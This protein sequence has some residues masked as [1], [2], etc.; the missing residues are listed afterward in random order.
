M[1]NYKSTEEKFEYSERLNT[2]YED[3]LKRLRTN[4]FREDTLTGTPPDGKEPFI[5]VFLETRGEPFPT[6]I[7]KAIVRSWMESEIP[8]YEGDIL[9]GTQRPERI[10]RE[11]FS[12]GIQEHRHMFDWCDKYKNRREELEPVLDELHSE[13]V[14]LDWDHLGDL[15]H[16]LFP[17]VDGRDV[18]NQVVT[19][20]LWW[21]GGFQGHTVP[22]YKILVT[23]GIGGVHKR[24][25]D[26][27]A[28]E[29]EQKKIEMLTACKIILEGLR[30][31]ILMHADKAEEKA[32]EGGKWA[33]SLL[34][35][36][37]NCRA[38]AFD[39]PENYYQACQL[40]WFYSLWDWVDCLGRF[41]QFL[42]PFFEKSLGEDRQFTEDLTAALMLK[43]L[44]HGIHNMTL[45]GCDPET[46]KDATNELSYLV[47]QIARRNHETHPRITLRIGED[48]DPALLAL[49]VKMWS[50]GMSDPTVSAD[51]TVIP[52]FVENYG[53]DLYDAR[54]YS[55]LG[56][57]ELEIPG[58]SNFGCEDGS[59]NLAKILEMTLNDG[60]TRF[61]D[62]YRVGLPTGH[63]TDYDSFEDFYAAYNS[64]VKFFTERFIALCNKGQEMRAAN[65]AKLVKTPFTEACIEKG[66]NLDDGG[67]VYNYGCVET[68][69]SS[70]VADSLT[71]IKKLV[72]EGK[73]ISKETLEAAI[74]A[75]FEGYEDVQVMLL[76]EAPKFGNDNDEADEMANRVLKDFWSEIKKYKSV[77]GGEFSGACSLLSGGIH[78]GWQTW[79]TPDGRF[80]GM[81]FGNSIGPVPGRD[82][83]GLTAM[84]SSVSKLPLDYGVGGTTCN[85]TIPTDHMKNEEMRAKIEALMKAFL[86]S[87]GQL[88]QITTANVEELKDAKIHPENHGN[89]IVRVGGFSI[90]FIEL[91]SSHQ[92]E[93]ISRYA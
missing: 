90:N 88:A 34:K 55:L 32:K 57:Q 79:A 91:D 60:Y 68:V 53:V 18:Y 20:G 64:Q 27:L 72:F 17:P 56:C 45:G 14:P 6:R 44:E 75:N 74:A 86:L 39:A 73:K 37:E 76:R 70:V 35:I 66:L 22:N 50:E 59:L 10:V 36:A 77:R 93:I 2:V 85:V 7:A 78:Y 25:C 16:E 46:G 81:P 82:K 92:D 38:V 63:I 11:H 29:T 24:V 89:L 15:A 47:L 8:I 65:Y 3:M 19:P 67:A 26:R 71:A 80:K 4:R 49:G 9:I 83:S 52:A 42:Y 61:D 1:K 33:D 23:Q 62:T 40:V 51:A 41:D 54:N 12:F 30:D 84:L 58:K 21:V 48:T 69:G 13:F 87:G 31:W 5:D 28:G 43:F